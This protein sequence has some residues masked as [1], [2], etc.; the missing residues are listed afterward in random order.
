MINE[1]TKTGFKAIRW[2][3]PFFETFWKVNRIEENG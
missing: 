2:A 1:F 3:N